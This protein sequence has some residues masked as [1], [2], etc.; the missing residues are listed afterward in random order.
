MANI[1]NNGAEKYS[2]EPENSFEL[3]VSCE[4]PGSVSAIELKLPSEDLIISDQ[5]SDDE[6][7]NI[8][9]IPDEM[10]GALPLDV[11]STSF[12][13]S[14]SRRPFA[15]ANAI[16]QATDLEN[17]Y[18]ITVTELRKRFA[19]DRALIYQF[20]SETHGT[21]IAEFLTAGYRPAL[22]QAV[23]ALAFGAPNVQSY[24]QQPII[25][26]AD[27]AEAA[28]KPYQMQLFQHFQV[29]ASLSLP[30]F[31]EDRLWGLLVIQNCGAPRQWTDSEIALLYQVG[32][33]LRD[34]RIKKIPV[35]LGQS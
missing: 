29:Q 34:L 16:A 13:S 10:V 24:E 1:I 2:E 8:P 7:P 30:I 12:P 19:I 33:E 23:V 27:I 20:Q 4:N 21:V 18:Q 5:F 14:Q 6:I 32:T 9:D 31:L 22:G 28:I 15:I 11:E 25:N 26:V 35:K 3:D 17:L